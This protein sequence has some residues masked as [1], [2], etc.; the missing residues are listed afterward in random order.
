MDSGLRSVLPRSVSLGKS[1]SHPRT[2]QP[3]HELRVM[4]NLS[5]EGQNAKENEQKAPSKGA[6]IGQA[7]RPHWHKLGCY[8]ARGR[9]LWPQSTRRTGRPSTE[10]GRHSGGNSGRRARGGRAARRLKEVSTVQHPET[11][12]P[13]AQGRGGRRPESTAIRMGR[14]PARLPQPR[15]RAGQSAE[16]PRDTSPRPCELRFFSTRLMGPAGGGEAAVLAGSLPARS[17]ARSLHPLY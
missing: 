17:L 14:G 1:Q 10:G 15:G 12:R 3:H 16:L 2:P 11:R 9:E 5:L 13:S 6:L 7:I 8:E 4:I